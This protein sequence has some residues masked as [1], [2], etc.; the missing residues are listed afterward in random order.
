MSQAKKGD[1]VRVH[2]TGTLTDGSKFDSSVGGDPLEF[3][4]GAGQVIA[5]FD[6]AVTGMS[7]GESCS[8]SIDAGNAYGERIDELVHE[9]PRNV[10]PD[11]MEPA[12]GMAL[13]ASTPEGQVTRLVITA[14]ADEA[15]TV[16]A[17]HPLAGEDLAFDIELVESV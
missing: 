8:V 12:V 15:V 6:D 4:V 11:D 13:Q 9:V 3:V 7:V 16:D 5:G 17:N 2:Y 1:T 14:V 10:L